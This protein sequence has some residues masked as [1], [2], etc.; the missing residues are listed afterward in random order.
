M[1]LNKESAQ[2]T[3]LFVDKSR[4]FAGAERSLSVVVEHLDKARFRPIIVAD[5][6]LLHHKEYQK[7]CAEVKCR[8]NNLKWWMGT[9]RWK[10]P[11]RGT[12]AFKRIIFAHKLKRLMADSGAKI[13][14]VNLLSRDSWVDLVTAKIMGVRT[15]GH[16]RSLL[17]Q[18]Y[19]N[20][21][22]LKY[23]D[24]VICISDYVTN[25]ISKLT[26]I[27]KIIK[28]YNPIPLIKCAR[29]EEKDTAKKDLNINPDK[30]VIS[31]VAMLDP[32]KGH[33][34]AITAFVKIAQYCPQ[35]I[36]LI[37]GGSYSNRTSTVFDRLK[38]LAR[39][40]GISERIK[41]TGFVD[42]MRNIYLAS[43]IVLAL[44]KDGEAFGRV[45]VESG[46]YGCVTVATAVGATPELII[47]GQTGFLVSP[48]NPNAV[49]EVCVRVL[50][51][52]TL[53]KNI[54]I[55]AKEHVEKKFNPEI[56][57]RQV[58]AVYERLLQK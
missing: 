15:V 27:S 29:P 58:E 1:S 18:R 10:R 53:A 51:D 56:I 24:S 48:N 31:S 52:A 16:V 22:C 26:S 6:P 3:V 20:N 43:D 44:S 34:I 30:D 4:A 8:A 50:N 40:L 49:A 2:T 25:E 5:Y 57:T 9:D 41:F 54:G 28:I 17:S 14:H 46:A 13:L 36:L 45:A 19:L 33:D 55:A 35:S 23:C 12:D 37:V 11:P 39:D 21:H 42:D 32:R 47:D 7:S 38:Q